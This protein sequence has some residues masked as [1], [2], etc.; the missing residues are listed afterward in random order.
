MKSKAFWDDILSVIDDGFLPNGL[1]KLER[2]AEQFIS[3][4]LVYK[5]F[6]PSEQRGCS[7]G[8]F[9]HVVASL[10][11]GAEVATDNGDSQSI[12][13]R[14]AE[15]KHGTKQ[16]SYIE[17]WAN[18]TGIW[19]DY[20]DE[21]LSDALGHYM[22]EGGEAKVY[23]NGTTIIKTIG[24]DYFIQ[25]IFALDRISL[26]NTF[27]PETRLSVIGFGR[28]RNGK[29]Q[30]LVE[31]PYIQGKH[32]TDGE[33]SIFAQKLGFKII[34]PKNWTYATPQIY[35]SDL[36]DENVI[37]SREGNIFVV[38]CDIRINTPDLKCGGTRTLTTDVEFL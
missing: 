31:Q 37:R 35:L 22:S 21:K 4:R 6:S 8:G 17:K 11:A 15:F 34:N 33:I 24:L 23:D 10:L 27:F 38:D 32:I 14:Q 20:I 16:E 5:R 13:N 28:E 18:K 9:T 29:F 26:H 19:Y 36:H 12:S 3:G 7:A 25:P 30:I 2:Y 1:Q